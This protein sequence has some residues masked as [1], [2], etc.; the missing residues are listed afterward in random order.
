MNVQKC[1]DYFGPFQ[2]ENL[3]VDLAVE[4]G[5]TS[6]TQGPSAKKQK[7]EV[8][9]ESILA[10]QE[11]ND[12]YSVIVCENESHVKAVL[13]VARAYGEKCVPFK[14]LFVEGVL[15]C[16]MDG[17]S[18][19]AEHVPMTPVVTFIGDNNNIL[20]MWNLEEMDFE[21]RIDARGQTLKQMCHQLKY[22]YKTIQSCIDYFGE[23]GIIF[24]EEEIWTKT[25]YPDYVQGL[26]S[27]AAG[28]N[29]KA[30]LIKYMFKSEHLSLRFLNGVTEKESNNAEEKTGG[31]DMP[32]GD[33]DDENGTSLFHLDR[34]GK[35]RF[36]KREAKWATTYLENIDLDGKAKAQL[37]KKWFEL[38]Q[39]STDVSVSYCN[40]NNYG[41]MNLL[42][43]CGV[44]RLDN[45]GVE[46][47]W[48]SPW[49]DI[50]KRS[51]AKQRK[52]LVLIPGRLRNKRRQQ[53]NSRKT[54]PMLIGIKEVHVVTKHLE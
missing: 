8:N 39:E 16:V 1:L 29:L 53:R 19:E 2:V 27:C 9:T 44:V 47:Q 17:W 15:H 12:D 45:G 42:W 18:G 22:T 35:V 34:E 6:K 38:P 11:E 10:S 30:N 13:E 3:L 52:K 49:S 41:K 48:S 32:S 33:S 28:D 23:I 46:P 51:Q 24:T 21:K 25:D 37:Q 14:I 43:V 36:T 20:S 40:E 4:N 26:K 54:H 5:M 50:R 7:T 31:K